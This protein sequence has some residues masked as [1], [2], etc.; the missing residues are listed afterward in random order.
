MKGDSLPLAFDSNDVIVKEKLTK[1]LLKKEDFGE[2]DVIFLICKVNDLFK[3]YTVET[4][5]PKVFDGKQDRENNI[6]NFNCIEIWQ[7]MKY[8][9]LQE[10][11]EL[12][13]DILRF[14]PEYFIP[15]YLFQFIELAID[16]KLFRVVMIF[17]KKGFSSINEIIEYLNDFQKS[18]K[19]IEFILEN[20]VYVKIDYR[21]N[22]INNFRKY[23]NHT[24]FSY[25]KSWIK[26]INE[27]KISRRKS[28]ALLTT[29]TAIKKTK[30]F[31]I[32][33]K[34]SRI[35]H[36][37]ICKEEGHFKPKCPWLNYKKINIKFC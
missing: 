29:T 35:L 20:E 12:I 14:R 5:Q 31:K 18:E 1:K 11:C 36:C 27:R 24:K 26:V 34:S 16:S 22:F 30:I 17:F 10:D 33:K 13:E 6:L 3:F 28:E 32:N 8:A 2:N 25:F 7:I 21:I 4:L 9:C 19:I 37:S 15:H 23:N